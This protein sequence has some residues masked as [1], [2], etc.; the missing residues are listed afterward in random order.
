MMHLHEIAICP[1][2]RKRELWLRAHGD[3]NEF[4][5]NPHGVI[6]NV[7]D[8]SGLDYYEKGKK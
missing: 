2:C 8:E 1:S 7:I 3:V 4:R 6:Y 5:V